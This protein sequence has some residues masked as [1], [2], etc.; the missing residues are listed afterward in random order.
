MRGKLDLGDHKLA[1]LY[2]VPL[3]RTKLRKRPTPTYVQIQHLVDGAVRDA[4]NKHPEYLTDIGRRRAV[5]SVVKRVTGT[6]HGYAMQIA[7]RRSTASTAAKAAGASV[8]A[9]QVGEAFSLAS[10]T[11]QSAG[12]LALLNGIS[13]SWDRLRRWSGSFIAQNSSESKQ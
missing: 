10:P 13:S 2:R 7:Q 6:L 12:K 5:G 11:E 4:F 9:Y 3:R 8:A 1:G